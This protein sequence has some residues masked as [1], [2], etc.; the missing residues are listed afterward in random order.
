MDA[1][2]VRLFIGALFVIV[3]TILI[4]I[5]FGRLQE[6]CLDKRGGEL[7]SIRTSLANITQATGKFRFARFGMVNRVMRSKIH[8]HCLVF[9]INNAWHIMAGDSLTVKPIPDGD[10]VIW[11]VPNNAP[12]FIR[13]NDTTTTPPLTTEVVPTND[14]WEQFTNS[15]LTSPAMQPDTPIQRFQTLADAKTAA[16]PCPTKPG[17]A[18]SYIVGGSAVDPTYYLVQTPYGSEAIT[19]STAGTSVYRRVCGITPTPVAA[20][21]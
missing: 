9:R 2:V 10:L 6:R 16:L 1:P 17:D 13:P 15:T 21:L 12:I 19:G 11:F 18:V 4:S 8:K 3:F 20:V 7:L 5:P 14:G